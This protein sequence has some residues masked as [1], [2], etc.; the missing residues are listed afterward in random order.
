M[1]AAMDEIPDEW[2]EAHAPDGFARSGW[3]T[4]AMRWD[5]SADRPAIDTYEVGVNGELVGRLERD[6]EARLAPTRLAYNVAHP[7]FDALRHKGESPSDLA[8]PHETTDSR[9]TS[10]DAQLPRAVVDLPSPMPNWSGLL[11]LWLSNAVR[12]HD[13]LPFHAILARNN[14]D[15]N[16][17][18]LVPDE[19]E[20]D[21]TLWAVERGPAIPRRAEAMAD[22]LRGMLRLATPL[23]SLIPTSRPTT[24]CSCV[25]CPRALTSVVHPDA[26]PGGTPASTSS[27]PAAGTRILRGST[28]RQRAARSCPPA[29]RWTS[30]S[31]SGESL[32]ARAGNGCTTGTS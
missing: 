15:R 6:T 14:P 1:D 2:F 12:E 13:R 29:S 9:E 23:S 11:D 22:T 32:R 19:L 24:G 31:R 21:S 25:S 18:I 4:L 27:R 10:T 26:F 7:L 20:G 28:S 17:R 3:V 30:R 5:R 16:P 8:A